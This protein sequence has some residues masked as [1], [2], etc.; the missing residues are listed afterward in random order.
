MRRFFKF[1]YFLVVGKKN[2]SLSHEAKA[3]YF[4]ETGVMLGS[5]RHTV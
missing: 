3:K 1:L 2:T 4:F 5:I